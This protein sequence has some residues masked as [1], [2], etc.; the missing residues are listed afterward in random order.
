MTLS[1][2]PCHHQGINTIRVARAHF[3]GHSLYCDADAA[4]AHV[5][6]TLN[7]RLY[8]MHL[9]SRSIVLYVERATSFCQFIA[10][11]GLLTLGASPCLRQVGESFSPFAL[12]AFIYAITFQPVTSFSSSGGGGGRRENTDAVATPSG[13][14][15]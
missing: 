10:A 3:T 15:W 9:L 2:A 14:K 4:F 6:F 1:H 8:V 11:N 13:R 5:T 7:C 12:A